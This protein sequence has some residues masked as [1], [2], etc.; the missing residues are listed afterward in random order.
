MPGDHEV[1]ERPRDEV[2]QL[3]EEVDAVTTPPARIA[4]RW[5]RIAAV[6]LGLVGVVLFGLAFYM[7]LMY[8]D[9]EGSGPAALVV[10]LVFGPAACWC[11]DRGGR[12]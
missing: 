12:R 7:N 6:A 11:W 10:V 2:D 5:W 8:G 4:T 1:F 3:R 9:Y